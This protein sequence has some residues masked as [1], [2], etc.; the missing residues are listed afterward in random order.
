M[1][2]K[3]LNIPRS[4]PSFPNE[5]AHGFTFPTFYIKKFISMFRYK[6]LTS[7]PS[8][9]NDGQEFLYF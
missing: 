2:F 5:G 3:K 4:S 9:G 7:S 1:D 6:L 8:L